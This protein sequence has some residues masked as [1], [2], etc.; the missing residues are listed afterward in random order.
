MKRCTHGEGAG[1]L[2]ARGG[3]MWVFHVLYVC[4]AEYMPV[5]VGNPRG[6][7]ALPERLTREARLL[8]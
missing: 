2:E 7:L 5:L 8:L 6:S 4:A 3:Y 1:D